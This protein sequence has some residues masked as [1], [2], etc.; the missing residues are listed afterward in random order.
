MD[1]EALVLKSPGKQRPLLLFVGLL[2]LFVGI[3][4]LATVR[5]PFNPQGLTAG[6]LQQMEFNGDIVRTST[7]HYVYNPEK[8]RGMP[9]PWAVVT[10][11]V[12]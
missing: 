6:Q 10:K 9:G 1:P 3:W 12:E 7:G 8:A 4:A 11:T 5:P 2:G